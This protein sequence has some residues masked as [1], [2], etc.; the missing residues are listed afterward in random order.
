MLSRNAERMKDYWFDLFVGSA[1]GWKLTAIN[2]LTVYYQHSLKPELLAK[3][4]LKHSFDESQSENRVKQHFRQWI[5]FQWQRLWSFTEIPIPNIRLLFCYWFLPEL[6]NKRNL[7][8]GWM[9]GYIITNTSQ[10]L[11]MSPRSRGRGRLWHFYS[12]SKQYC[13]VWQL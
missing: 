5:T 2:Q 4:T 12:Y 1:S 9:S 10:K 3:L 8:Y 7:K 13:E 6:K 11:G